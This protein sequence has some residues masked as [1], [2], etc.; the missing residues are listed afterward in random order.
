MGAMKKLALAALL[1]ALPFAAS[2][3]QAPK[4]KEIKT[5]TIN[6]T[7]LGGETGPKEIKTTTINLTG[8]GGEASGPREIKTTT[9][10]LTGTRK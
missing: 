1:A 9:I 10:N 3:Q 4:P 6:L 5:T 8:L 2:A 7:G